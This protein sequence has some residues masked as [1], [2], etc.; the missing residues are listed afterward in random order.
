MTQCGSKC[1][2]KVINPQTNVCRV[3]PIKDTGPWFTVDDWWNPTATR[4]LNNLASNPNT[5]A[6]GYPAAEAA[7]NGLDVGYGLGPNGIGRDNTG[8]T[9]GRPYR[10]V[11]NPAA[12]DLADGTWYAI[13]PA[14]NGIGGT[15]T[16][17]ML[18]QTGADPASSAAA[19]GHPLNQVPGDPV[20]FPPGTTNPAF[21]G[22]KVPIVNSASTPSTVSATT[23][24]D[25]NLYT[26]WHSGH[27][28]PNT[29]SLRFDLGEDKDISGI[30]W[31]FYGLGYSDSFSVVV[32][33]SDGSVRNL[34]RFG[35]GSAGDTWY[36]VGSSSP[37]RGRYV[38][39]LFDNPNR[40]SAVGSISEVEIWAQKSIPPGQANPGF[41]GTKLN[42]INSA[43]TPSTVSAS[44]AHDGNLATNWHSGHVTPGSA[45]LR[46][47]LG[48]EQPISGVKW[49][50]YGL[51]FADEF[52]VVLV[53]E[54]GVERS[55]GTFGNGSSGANW[56]GVAN[57]SGFRAR[58]VRFYFANPNRDSAVGSIAEVEVWGSPLHSPGTVNP[59]F[60]GRQ[61]TVAN[62]AS[63][64]RTISPLLA[65]DGNIWTNWHSGHSTPGLASLRLDL[66][67]SQVVTGVKWR[68]YGTGYADQFSVVLVSA[69]GAELSL[70][71]F[72]NGTST[73]AFYGKAV[74][75]GFNARYVRFYFDNPNR[76]SAVG[77]ISE[78]Q[79]FAS[80]TQ[81]TPGILNPGFAGSR[82]PI[83]N[84]AD[85]PLTGLSI[86]ARDGNTGTN[87][88]I[89]NN[90]RSAQLRFDVGSD[91]IM[92]GVK[93][94][95]AYTGYAHHFTVVLV[96][97]TGET[98]TFG[99]FGN[100][101]VTQQWYGFTVPGGFDARYVRFY[102][103]NTAGATALGSVAE[104][105]IW[106]SG[107][108]FAAASMPT[109]TDSE[110][111]GMSLPIVASEAT[112]G[113]PRL[114][115]DGDEATRFVASADPALPVTIATFD[116]GGARDLTGL[117]WQSAAD[118]LLTLRTSIDGQTWSEVGSFANQPDGT[119]W[120]G[121]ALPE[122]TTARY[123]QVEFTG[124]GTDALAAELAEFEVWGLVE[125]PDASPEAS[126]EASPV[127][128]E[129]ETPDASPVPADPEP[130]TDASPEPVQP[131]A[132]PTQTPTATATEP[133][134]S[135]E[136]APEEPTTTATLESTPTETLE[137]TAT[138]TLEPTPTETLEPTATET[139]EPTATETLEPTATATTEPMATA[140][141]TAAI[142]IGTIT[143]ADDD[144]VNCRITPVDGDPITQLDEGE[145][146]EVTGEAVD[147]W[148]PVLCAGQ[149]GW[150][151]A[152]FVT[153][154]S[155]EPTEEGGA[156]AEPTEEATA[157]PTEEIVEEPYPIV[158]TG[159]TEDSGTA[160]LASDDDSSTWWSVFPS[161]SPEQTRLYLDLGSVQ[162]I[163]RIDIELAVEGLLPYFELWLSEDGETWYN[164]T[165]N[166]ING[167]T[168]WA[169]EAHSFQLG[170]DARYVRI[171]IPNVDESGLTEV[172]G[173]AEVTIWPGDITATQYLTALGEPTTPTPEPVE[174]EPTAEPTEEVVEE[175]TE[176]EVLEPTEDVLTEPTEEVVPTE[177][178]EPTEEI[179]VE[180][181]VEAVG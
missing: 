48:V 65:H 170:Y 87:W 149:P 12:I 38:R 13:A 131:T 73:S 142:S 155:A 120:Q 134:A 113:E 77:S 36:G 78:V 76:D 153:L 100:G 159:D 112:T 15:I 45:S 147:G 102:Y 144:A 160:W 35:N 178:F 109:A 111:A 19:C 82:L 164:A 95:F 46:L 135:P 66:G 5:L 171:V 56:Y 129:V 11:G 69:S 137:P 86:R 151:S 127:V 1:Y 143:G 115:H 179:P 54:S 17:E 71:T 106:G 103:T 176:E 136:P 72:G 80:G 58:Y 122:G 121:T 39:L 118:D 8:T 62:S 133:A 126:P 97:S 68:F 9:P 28:T 162:P 173:I 21:T 31:K 74:P 4:Y 88:S 29:A 14:H 104:V 32:I 37:V 27:V 22:A 3:E 148:L 7:R 146:V 174:E 44:T 18:W 52:R 59:S 93:W 119:S 145:Q 47:D 40:D 10:E 2:V 75:S 172:G 50:F 132:E 101:T 26:N 167:W 85:T 166:G 83:T 49:R 91:R 43:S 33:A 140:E 108:S 60:S 154:G 116:L 124:T 89:G 79:V 130:P 110:F 67:T 163:D 84:S 114:A 6:Q 98:L 161:Q 123:V 141:P 165:P 152:A 96:S 168:L 156:T 23:A 158:D 181:T 138:A 20:S 150:I 51:G 99:P 92:Y 41:S 169:G 105:E 157:E 64:P 90:P 24:H 175:P 16:V 125:L 61:V 128:V 117:R 107:A 180:E 55:L 63:T 30:K 70:G 57:S 34:G 94:K 25:N 139:L 81:N 42:V 53:S 177:Q